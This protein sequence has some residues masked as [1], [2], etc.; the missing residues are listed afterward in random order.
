MKKIVIIFVLVFGGLLSAS[1]T[2]A[3]TLPE[4]AMCAQIEEDLDNMG[5]LISDYQHY[6][7]HSQSIKNCNYLK[8]SLNNLV[9]FYN[10]LL[11]IHMDICG[12]D[13]IN[14]FPVDTA[15]CDID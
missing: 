12:G 3:I 11:D 5:S 8:D 1:S 15:S 7:D 9:G 10:S 4:K 13:D 2:K 14:H 6:V